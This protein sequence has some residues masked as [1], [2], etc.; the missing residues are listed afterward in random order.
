[1]SNLIGDSTKSVSEQSEP[2]LAK[3]LTSTQNLLLKLPPKNLNL[4]KSTVSS[5]NSQPP[6]L[7]HWFTHLDSLIYSWDRTF[8]QVYISPPDIRTSTCLVS[9]T[10]NP[11]DGWNVIWSVSANFSYI[12]LAS[13]IVCA[14]HFHLVVKPE[15]NSLCPSLLSFG[16]HFNLKL[17]EDS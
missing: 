3:H 17:T 15:R 9:T 1:M 13:F 10:N 12:I 8:V 7:T 14:S 2:T 16:K 11:G 5:I 6:I 4:P